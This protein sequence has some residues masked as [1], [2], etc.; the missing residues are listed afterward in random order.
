MFLIFKGLSQGQYKFVR[1]WRFK[2]LWELDY[3]ICLYERPLSKEPPPFYENCLMS[4]S[5]LP[6]RGSSSE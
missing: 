4:A 1:H 3:H 6:K 5:S 2:E